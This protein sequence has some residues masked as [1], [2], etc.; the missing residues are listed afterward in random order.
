MYYM[1]YRLKK[2]MVKKIKFNKTSYVLLTRKHKPSA[3]KKWEPLIQ[4]TYLQRHHSIHIY[5]SFSYL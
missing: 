4:L 3:K 2:Y 1:I 5:Y